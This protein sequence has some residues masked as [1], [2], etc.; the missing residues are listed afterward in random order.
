M[1]S[2]FSVATSRAGRAC[3][4]AVLA[5]A[6]TALLP[7]PAG[8]AFPGTN[9]K[10]AFSSPRSG[11]PTEGNLFTM[12]ADGSGQTAITSFNGDELYPAWSPSGSSIAF[13]QDPGLHPEIW[14]ANPDGT[15]LRQLTSNAA[16]DLHPSWSP[17]GTQIVFASDRNSP[18]GNTSDLFVMNADGTG[19]APITNTPAVDEDYPAWSPDGRSIAFSRDGDLATVAPDGTGLVPLTATERVEFEPDWAPNNTQLVFRTGINADDEVFRINADGTG[20]TNLTNTGSSVEEHPAWSPDGK[21]VLFTKGA[22]GTAEVW[23]MNPD[24]TGQARLTT[25]TF[26]DAQ[27]SW[28][29]I[30]A[31]G[32]P[33]PKST[34]RFQTYYLVP[35]YRQ[36]TSPNRTHGPPMEHASCNPPVQTSTQLSPGT[37]DA[38]GHP[39]AW[40]SNIRIKT[41]LGDPAT[42]LDE[43]DIKFT[44]KVK[45]VLRQGTLLDYNR[46][47]RVEVGVRLT[48]KWNNPHPGG[49]GPGTGSF[50]LAWS[51][52]CIKTSDTARGGD[53][54]NA[55]KA[56]ALV[57]GIVRE[58]SRAIWEM[59]QLKVYDGG[60]D[61]DGDT[62][63][64]NTLLAVQGLFV[65]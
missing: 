31:A 61:N 43:S 2:H 38:N 9:G 7:A 28:Q 51:I 22:F 15:N 25:N 52:P 23:T 26:M 48:D 46:E 33:R 41:I 19:Q 17:D 53:C 5:A 18:S 57:P 36:C 45:D 47:L 54:V 24:G 65:P 3:A 49:A 4:I 64:D 1:G 30:V 55:T 32:F 39:V 27:P 60:P 29:P 56:D 35:A 63:A 21:K 16:D 42:T 40:V 10:I 13:Q 11:F 14:S 44:T 59:D 6:V 20:V 62:T 58:K 37:F 34:L 50:K 12:N 8:A